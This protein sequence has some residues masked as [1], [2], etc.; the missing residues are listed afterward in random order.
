[1]QRCIRALI[2]GNRFYAM[3]TRVLTLENVAQDTAEQVQPGS[4]AAPS[5]TRARFRLIQAVVLA[6]P[7]VPPRFSCNQA[8]LLPTLRMSIAE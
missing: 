1:M 3:I 7:S 4:T 6:V 2:S 5:G 8:Q